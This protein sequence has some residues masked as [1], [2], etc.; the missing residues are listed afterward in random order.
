MDD[1]CFG[2]NTI[3]A[4]KHRILRVFAMFEDGHMPLKK[5]SSNSQEIG[6]FIRGQ[7]PVPDPIITTNH[8]EAKFLGIPWN[9]G[10]DRLSAPV[11]KAWETLTAGTPCKRRLLRSLASI[12]DP[13]GIVAPLTM[14]AKILLQ[15]TWKTKLGWDSTL[16]ETQT[17]EFNVF[18][19]TLK[20]AKDLSIPRLM[21]GSNEVSRTL[22]IFCDASL[23]AYG[24]V[25]YLREESNNDEPYVSFVI[26]KARVAPIKAMTIHRLELLAALIGAKI[27]KLISSCLDHKLSRTQFYSDNS[28]VVG[29]IRSNPEKFKPFVANRIRRIQTL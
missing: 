26:A 6:D 11:D 12:F 21:L 20:A 1:V 17:T 8:A 16:S 24:C 25:A 27:S 7:S 10:S 2:E 4:A 14:N 15:S 3:E 9:Q 23:K 13:L 22:H 29:W 18:A 5:W 19:E 28:S